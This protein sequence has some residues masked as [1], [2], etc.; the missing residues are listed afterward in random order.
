MYRYAKT[1]NRVHRV[2]IEGGKAFKVEQCNLD[3][4]GFLH[5]DDVEPDGQHCAYC[6][7]GWVAPTEEEKA[8]AEEAKAEEAT[9]GAAPPN[10]KQIP[11]VQSTRRMA[12]AALALAALIGGLGGIALSPDNQA[13][14]RDPLAAVD[15]LHRQIDDLFLQIHVLQA[16]I[17]DLARRTAA[18]GPTAAPVIIVVPTA[19]PAPE[20]TG[21]PATPEPTASAD[22]SKGDTT[23]V[24]IVQPPVVPTQ[25]PGQQTVPTPAP[26]VVPTP[27]PTP[28]PTCFRPGVARGA[29]PCGWPQH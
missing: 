15:E 6:W 29:D 9:A 11:L 8:K 16:D 12:I 3:D 25:K 1:R 28:D 4:V 10:A 27:Q 23:T 22:A 24:I 19:P 2:F 20:P 7:A 5:L 21:T 14:A 26:T 17:G 18:P 13:A